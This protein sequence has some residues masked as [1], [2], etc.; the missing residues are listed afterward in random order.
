MNKSVCP[1]VPRGESRVNWTI[2]CACTVKKGGK[3]VI[4]SSYDSVAYVQYVHNCTYIARRLGRIRVMLN[5]Q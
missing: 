2:A 3:D 5:A 1:P 4:P